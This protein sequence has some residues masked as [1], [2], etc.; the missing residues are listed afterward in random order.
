V[1]DTLV[2]IVP[3]FEQLATLDAPR[4]QLFERLMISLIDKIRSDQRLKGEI[5][6]LGAE[7][8]LRLMGE[9]NSEDAWSNHETLGRAYR[10][11]ARLS[12]TGQQILL[13][14]LLEPVNL[15]SL[16]CDVCNKTG[17]EPVDD[18][19]RAILEASFAEGALGGR[20][21]LETLVGVDLLKACLA[22]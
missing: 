3:L 12:P 5:V 6:R 17:V 13:N 2:N 11:A 18:D 22:G 21:L 19:V 15:V 7:N 14:A 16:Y 1:K 8:I 10:C 9:N 4:Q 20:Q